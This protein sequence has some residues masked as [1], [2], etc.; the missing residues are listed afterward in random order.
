MREKDDRSKVDDAVKT[1][2]M[3]VVAPQK[4]RHSF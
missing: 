4:Q 1:K 2:K 3:V